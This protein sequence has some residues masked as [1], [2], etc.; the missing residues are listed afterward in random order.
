MIKPINGPSWRRI[1]KFD[2]LDACAIL[3]GGHSIDF[4][5]AIRTQY[6]EM[7]PHFP[8]A[9]PIS[10]GRYY[11]KNITMMNQAA[12]AN[13][14]AGL[15][16]TLSSGM[17]PNGIYRNSFRFYSDSDPEGFMVYWQVERYNSMGDD[18]F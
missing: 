10:K 18:R 17:M 1:L 8:K 16:R 7:F 4:I 15:F 11:A 13:R 2:N 12:E 14:S 9:C 3:S 5:N 6:L